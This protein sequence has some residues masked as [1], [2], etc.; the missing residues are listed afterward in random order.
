MTPDQG[1]YGQA[2]H[3]HAVRQVTL[4]GAFGR[5]PIATLISPP[6]HATNRSS[7]NTKY[8]RLRIVDTFRHTEICRAGFGPLGACL[9]TALS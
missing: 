3:V 9:L 5:N 2:D 6:K 8:G 4:N 7:L 1:H